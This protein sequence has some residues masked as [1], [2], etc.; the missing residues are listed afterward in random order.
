MRKYGAE[1]TGLA[2]TSQGKTVLAARF[3]R[4]RAAFFKPRA[5]RFT[6]ELWSNHG[7][8]HRR[9]RGQAIGSVRSFG[10]DGAGFFDSQFLE[11]QFFENTPEGLPACTAP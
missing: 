8:L 3:R 9:A 7:K 5:A 4:P 10:Y 1:C 6:R 2:M 11:S